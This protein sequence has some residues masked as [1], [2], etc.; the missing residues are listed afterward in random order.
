MEFSG[1]HVGG[2]SAVDNKFGL[3]CNNSLP[4]KMKIVILNLDE[5]ILQKGGLKEFR[6]F[7]TVEIL[8]KKETLSSLRLVAPA[9]EPH[10]ETIKTQMALRH[11]HHVIAKHGLN[12][13]TKV[14]T[15]KD[16]KV[17]I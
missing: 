1:N 5:E 8:G 9:D 12:K 4:S 6:L 16:K 17:V 10:L 13:I 11:V 3:I 2:D 15:D 14:L 7:T